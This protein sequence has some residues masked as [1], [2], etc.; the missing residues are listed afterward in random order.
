[1]PGG[2]WGALPVEGTGFPIRRQGVDWQLWQ[3]RPRFLG[4][5]HFE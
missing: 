4:V 2:K 5:S 1:M 3:E